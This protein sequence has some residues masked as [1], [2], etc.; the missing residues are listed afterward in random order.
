MTVDVSSSGGGGSSDAGNGGT[1]SYSTT[2]DTVTVSGEN[3]LWTGITY[4][5]QLQ[6]SNANPVLTSNNG[7]DEITTRSTL[8]NSTRN[9]S[10]LVEI[11]RTSSGGFNSKEVTIRENTPNVQRTTTR[12]LTDRAARQFFN[13]SAYT[14][15]NVLAPSSYVSPSSQFN[16]TLYDITELDDSSVE[17]LFSDVY[18]RTDATLR[19]RSLIVSAQPDPTGDDDTEY[20][21]LN[22]MTAV[23]TTDWTLVAE[24]GAT[25]TLSSGT[26]EGSIYLVNDTSAFDS[27]YSSISSG[28]ISQLDTTLDD[29]GENLSL[30]DADGDIRDELAYS[31][32]GTDAPQTSRGWTV[33]NVAEGDVTN[34]SQAQYFYTDSDTAADWGITTPAN[35]LGGF[36]STTVTDLLPQ[37]TN[38]NQS[39]TFTF[40]QD[41]SGSETV[42]I[43]LD[44]PQQQSPRQV[45]YGGNGGATAGSVNN[46]NT[47][48]GT[49]SIEWQAPSGGVSSGTTVRVWASGIQTG[50]TGQQMNPYEVTITRD[51]TGES[52]TPTFEVGTNTGS[53]DLQA[54]S[55]SDLA[56][57]TNSQTQTI[58]FEPSTDLPSGEVVSISLADAESA[59]PEITYGNSS[60]NVNTGGGSAQFQDQTATNRSIRYVAPQSGVTAGTTIEIEVTQ[61]YTEDLSNAPY[62]V[63][64]SRGDAGTASTTF[65]TSQA[66]NT[67]AVT[68]TEGTTSGSGNSVIEFDLENT[69]SSRVVTITDISVD[70]TDTTSP[71]ASSVD[72][73]DNSNEFAGAGGSL[74]Q[75][76]T[77]GGATESL[78][79]NATIDPNTQETFTLGEFRDG[80]GN[81]N[82]IGMIGQQ[83]TITLTF[84]DGSTRQYNINVQ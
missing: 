60:A 64:F 40:D 42:T 74:D 36:Q 15:A 3:G 84:S 34:R 50:P 18:G 83:A 73:E 31:N 13:S 70:S 65:G 6:F 71:S 25:T 80:P 11:E 21:E 10:I 48:S 43:N 17:V 33:N 39:F 52:T 29:G 57:D 66:Q 58:Q 5:D 24:N 4:T 46:F 35:V 75:P 26:T 19:D 67:N 23:D 69:D 27:E 68:G 63:A 8:R 2:S 77:I 32:D 53:S 82:R 81:G 56:A 62:S 30:V 44:N 54:L 72:T 22:F 20:V 1:S 59:T 16:R 38:Q 55:V 9:Y 7:Y 45:D 61:V 51:D 12:S 76:I 28:Q 49:A 78:D 79:N 37:T 14:G 47:N 41:V